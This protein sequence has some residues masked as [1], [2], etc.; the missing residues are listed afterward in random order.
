M[1][2]ALDEQERLPMRRVKR[3]VYVHDN[4]GKDKVRRSRQNALP[5]KQRS[6]T[7]A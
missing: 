6:R 7:Y 2:F 1:R 3:F 5:A 4:V